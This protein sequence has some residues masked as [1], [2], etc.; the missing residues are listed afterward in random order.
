ML[1]RLLRHLTFFLLAAAVVLVPALVVAGSMRWLAQR[2][3]EMLARQLA[4]TF[5][6]EVLVG[7]VGGNLITGAVVEGAALAAGEKLEKGA[8][9]AADRIT[10]RYDLRSV[11]RQGVAVPAAISEVTIERPRLLIVQDS[12]GRLNLQDIIPKTRPAPLEKRFRGRVHIRDGTL[13]FRSQAPFVHRGSLD[14]TLAGLN[15]TLD[16]GRPPQ[17]RGAFKARCLSS[18]VGEVD[19][20][21]TTDPE[22]GLL[23]LRAALDDVDLAWAAHTFAPGDAFRVLGGRGQVEGHVFVLPGEG[24][25]TVD[26]GVHGSVQR[27]RARI[28]ALG[29]DPVRF[30]GVVWAGTEG[31]RIEQGLVDWAGASWDLA[32]TVSHYAAPVVDL[33][34][35][36]DQVPASRLLPMLPPSARRDWELLR[37]GPISLDA[38]VI[39]PASDPDIRA[40]ARVAGGL[41]GRVSSWGELQLQTADVRASVIGLKA[42]AVMADAELTGLEVPR[43]R[44][45]TEPQKDTWPRAVSI[46]G[47]RVSRVHAEWTGQTPTVQARIH[48][49]TVHVDALAVN[50]LTADV[51]LHGDVVAVPTLTAQALGGELRAEG[52]LWFG[53]KGPVA[54]AKGALRGVDLS[55]LHQLPLAMPDE[56]SGS[57]NAEFRAQYA[58]GRAALEADLTAADV[59]VEKARVALVT[60]K[61]GATLDSQTEA[62]GKLTLQGGTYEGLQAK[63][64]EV[65]ASLHGS[66]VEVAGGYLRMDPGTLWAKGTA[67]LNTHVVEADVRLAEVD[68]RQVAGWLG[69][70]GPGGVAYFSGRV[71]GDWNDPTAQGALVVFEPSYRDYVWSGLAGDLSYQGDRLRAHT[72][73]ANLGQAVLRASGTVEG[74]RERGQEARLAGSVEAAGVHL[75][76][77]GRLL[78][79]DWPVSGLG[80]VEALVSGTVGRPEARGRLQLANVQ[81]EQIYADDAELTFR[82]DPEQLVVS[83]GTVETLGAAVQ[84]RGNVQF[85]EPAQLE[86]FLTAERVNLGALPVLLDLDLPLRGTVSIES[87]TVRGPVDNLAGTGR[88]V[89]P[90]ITIANETVRDLDARLSLAAGALRL[91]STRLT[92]AGGAVE[93]EGSYSFDTESPSLTG[94]AAVHGVG[95]SPLLRLAVPLVQALED[96]SGGRRSGM[97]RQLRRWALRL[98]GTLDGAFEVSGPA[99]Q[100]V[101]QAEL[102]TS[103]AQLDGKDLPSIEGRATLAGRQLRDVSV[104]MSQGEALVTAEGEADLDGP[105]AFTVEGSGISMAQ[106]RPWLPRAVGLGGTLGFT[107]VVSGS[108]RRPEAMASLDIVEPSLS[109]VRFDVLTVPIATLAEGAIGID[110]LVLKRGEQQV[111]LNGQLPFSWEAETL[112]A[113]GVARRGPGMPPEGKLALGAKIEQT[114]L[115][116][117]PGI[118]AEYMANRSG[119]RPGAGRGLDWSELEAEGTLDS[120]V[121]ITGTMA[122]KE[123]RGFARITDGAF[124]LPHWHTA[125]RP[126]NVDIQFTRL[127]DEN[128]VSVRRMDLGYQDLRAALS[129]QVIVPPALQQPDGTIIRGSSGLGRPL[130]NTYDLTLQLS[131]PQQMLPGGTTLRD[132]GGSLALQTTAPELHRLEIREL[133]AKLGEGT[134]RLDGDVDLRALALPDLAKNGYDLRLTLDQARIQHSRI[135][136]TEAEGWLELVTP[137]AGQMALRGRLSVHDGVLGLPPSGTGS[138]A[139][140]MGAPGNWP[141]VGLDVQVALG[142]RITVRGA[143]MTVPLERTPTAAVLTGTPQE[144][145]LRGG[146]TARRGGA[147]LPVGRLTIEELTVDYS[148]APSPGSTRIPRT[149]ELRQIVRGRASTTVTRAAAGLAQPGGQVRIV[150]DISGALPDLVI[151][152]TSE[153]PLSNEQILSL[154]AGA[155]ISPSGSSGLQPDNAQAL[156]SERVMETM[157]AALR[158]QVFAP[159]EEELQRLLGLSQLGFSFAYDQPV[160]VQVGKYLVENLLVTYRHTFA[161]APGSYEMELSYRL[162]SGLSIN[163]YQREGDDS[164]FEIG[165]RR[166]F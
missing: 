25:P 145:R 104:A 111:V 62:I 117:L 135:L 115:Q 165:Y 21:L 102:Q 80:T 60:A 39:G 18:Q 14:V 118:I 44:L 15:G 128:R 31:V 78:G 138:A 50:G 150:M 166:S 37:A 161:D 71:Q 127:G 6:R 30:S 43:F 109:G 9:L 33:T 48:V 112:D 54:T 98:D 42:P 69:Q 79:Q 89:A 156:L 67:D 23:A 96:R 139:N 106:L 114:S 41:R 97:A 126:V 68:V 73:Y 164:R 113:Q 35:A 100:P 22:S 66:R 29:S 72:L 93:L 158:V 19:V 149:L 163:L 110:T 95:I 146:V 90:E 130:R 20:Q 142:D 24:R 63:E 47:G 12:S 28:A 86:A 45:T 34:L 147:S 85:T 124:R 5:G 61:V 74:L 36:C 32:G 16:L 148:L 75:E 83:A 56:I 154:L 151:N 153:P 122:D 58:G 57:A 38:T 40:R 11:V 82:V 1:G 2:G 159:L 119:Q 123:V 103:S 152:A 53:G 137:A 131:A 87:A 3:Q 26:F 55:R 157:A 4:D 94:N 91:E 77:V 120:S 162:P 65:L 92:A 27:L 52:S 134:V 129:G 81:Y 76:R 121:D 46:A 64:G 49:P 107:V 160:S 108:A 51:R 88:V 17:I 59:Q 140:L 155:A 7:P 99:R 133:G 70:E 10:A 105:V 13:V 116:V 125:V 144:P 136:D 143:G 141:A 84:V 101:V 8:V 132:F